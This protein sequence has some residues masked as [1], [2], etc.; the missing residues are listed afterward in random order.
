MDETK[1]TVVYNNNRNM[2]ATDP[3]DKMLQIYLHEQKEGSSS[4]WSSP[5]GNAM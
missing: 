2:G 1:P 3:G 4:I 5:K